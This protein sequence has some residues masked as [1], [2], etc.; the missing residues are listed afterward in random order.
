ME[1]FHEFLKVYLS[2]SFEI[3]AHCCCY[4][5]FFGQA[6]R[7]AIS[8]TLSILCEVKCTILVSVE[9]LEQS[10]KFK[11][12]ELLSSLVLLFYFTFMNFKQIVL[13]NLA[14]ESVVGVNELLANL[15]I[16]LVTNQTFSVAI[17]ASKHNLN[18]ERCKLNLLASLECLITLNNGNKAAAIRILFGKFLSDKHGD[19]V[20]V[21]VHHLADGDFISYVVKHIWEF[22][23]LNS[24]TFLESY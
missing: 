18:L 20:H 6:K 14:F 24:F 11:L 17:T 12:I 21:V 5:F 10:E 16:L 9:L 7:S 2:V 22:F 23:V 1:I 3:C 15:G 4:Y 8:Q 13:F 19:I